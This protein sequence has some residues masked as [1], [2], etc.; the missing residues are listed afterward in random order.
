MSS[1]SVRRDIGMLQT[2]DIHYA[3]AAGSCSVQSIT[4]GWEFPRPVCHH[5][6]QKPAR[7]D[8]PPL[9]LC[10]VQNRSRTTRPPRFR[11]PSAIM[12]I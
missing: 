5:L 12:W 2:P 4:P 3:R 7:K 8:F 11:L 6:V 9:Q 1:M 10:A